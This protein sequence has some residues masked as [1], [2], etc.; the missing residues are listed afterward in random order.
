[1]GSKVG[2]VRMTISCRDCNA[3]VSSLGNSQIVCQDSSISTM[4]VEIR[5]ISMQII[6]SSR[7]AKHGGVTNGMDSTRWRRILRRSREENRHDTMRRFLS[8]Y[9]VSVIA[10]YSTFYYAKQSTV[11]FFHSSRKQWVK[12]VN[13]PVPEEQ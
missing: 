9:N 3:K 8:K 4:S 10:L 2:E 12:G 13:A 5:V 6:N 1:M 11:R 7:S